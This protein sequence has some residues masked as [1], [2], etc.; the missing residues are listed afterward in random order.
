MHSYKIRNL[1]YCWCAYRR[2]LVV[3]QFNLASLLEVLIFIKLVSTPFLMT[4]SLHHY[5]IGFYLRRQCHNEMYKCAY[6]AQ[7]IIRTLIFLTMT[8]ESYSFPISLSFLGKLMM[9]I[10]VKVKKLQRFSASKTSQVSKQVNFL[11]NRGYFCIFIYF[12]STSV[13]ATQTRILADSWS[14]PL[15]F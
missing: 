9:L 13:H 5:I 12:A 15:I 3:Y 2:C 4:V 8:L 7:R 6:S 1:Q 11:I 14:N 10:A